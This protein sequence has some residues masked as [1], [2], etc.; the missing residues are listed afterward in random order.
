[1]KMYSTYDINDFIICLGY[2]GYVIK[3]YFANYFLH[4][5]DV[6]LDIQNNKMEINKVDAE[7]WKITLVDTGEN[8]M[9][10]GRLK[11]I[12][13]YIDDTF[14]MTYGDGVSDINI[15]DLTKTH[16]EN[17]L[18]S[19]ITAVQPPGRFGSLQIENGKV[20]KFIEKPDGDYGWINGGFF[21]F[22]PD[23]FDYIEGD[24]TVLEKRPLETL[25]QEG[26]LGSFKHP[27]F[28]RAVDTLRDKEYL[29]T[30][31]ESK[32]TPWKSW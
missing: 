17:K 27:G 20:S 25:S 28:W 1:M 24:S 6:T 21:V 19:T 3:E 12:R 32:N 7:P 15:N 8:T 29:E 4:M 18:I 31:W 5:S 11:R 26:Q 9:T 22:E 23:V 16:K 10:G 14:C 13:N 30:L 2:K